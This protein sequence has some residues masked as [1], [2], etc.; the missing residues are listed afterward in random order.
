MS[1]SSNLG[2][3]PVLLLAV[4]Q[5]LTTNTKDISPT[6]SP[7]KMSESQTNM[8]N[9]NRSP[10]Q[11]LLKE[12]MKSRVKSNSEKALNTNDNYS[13]I[14][15]AKVDDTN[16]PNQL[17][18]V[19]KQPYPGM[20]ASDFAM[21]NVLTTLAAQSQGLQELEQSPVSLVKSTDT[22]VTSVLKSHPSKDFSGAQPGTVVKKSTSTGLR[23][24]DAL[25]I[26]VSKTQKLN[27]ASNFKLHV[28]IKL[29]PGSSSE[30]LDEGLSSESPQVGNG[31]EELSDAS[32]NTSPALNSEAI[33]TLLRM[34]LAMQGLQQ[35]SVNMN[36]LVE[37]VNQSLSQS[38]SEANTEAMMNVLTSLAMQNSGKT[39]G[40]P[41]P[42][43]EVSNKDTG[44]AEQNRFIISYDPETGAPQVQGIIVSEGVAQ[45]IDQSGNRL[46]IQSSETFTEDL[47]LGMNQ[48]THDQGETY[49]AEVPLD[50]HSGSNVTVYTDPNANPS[51]RSPCPVCGDTISGFHYGIFTCESCK[52]FFKRT[53]QN[54]KTFLCHRQGECEINLENRKKCPA[55]RFAK[56]LV[57]GMKLEAIRADR[58]RGGRSSYSGT[59]TSGDQKVKTNMCGPVERKK[60][61]LIRRSSSGG[62]LENLP[63]TSQGSSHLV[64]VLNNGDVVGEVKPFVPQILTDIMNL[65]S[66]LCDDDIPQEIG[67]DKLNMSDPSVFLTF[68]QLA[69]LKLYKI[70]RWARNLPYFANISTDDQILLLQNCWCELLTLT[71]CWRSMQLHNE[72]IFLHGQSL[73]EEKA[74]ILGIEDMFQSILALIE[75]LRRLHL[76]QYECVALKVIILICPDMKGLKDV[77]KLAE[78]QQRISGALETYT[79]THYRQSPNK[80]GE[81]IL[82]LSE[83]SRISFALKGHLVKWMPPNSTSCGLLFELLKGENMKDLM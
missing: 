33:K 36:E 23:N 60:P 15:E 52:G 43:T 12:I 78:Q 22:N 17:L 48:S 63:E 42:D 7:S 31:T 79:S 49:T 82:R 5:S 39:A 57:M 75:H 50:L 70:V 30:N 74:T 58:T 37:E 9:N 61:R 38:S 8:E 19:V 51:A 18:T 1:S 46:L 4:S 10:D 25:N 14:I 59:P 29:E 2:I 76:D 83:L 56:C 20:A 68:L 64:A 41:E 6:A 62:P 71:M 73:D 11:D 24:S 69:E 66:L 53:V 80:F 13:N 21:A 34:R 26:K 44:E 16:D 32:D 77:D 81:L 47:Q 55:C 67:A 54:K 3:S 65:E 35:S 28:P 72:V 45:V 27:S 40:E